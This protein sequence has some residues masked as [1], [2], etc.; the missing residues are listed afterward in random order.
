[1]ISSATKNA[2]SDNVPLIGTSPPEE[3]FSSAFLASPGKAVITTL[4]V[5]VSGMP[6]VSLSESESGIASD[7][8]TAPAGE[9]GGGGL[10]TAIDGE[11]GCM[12]PA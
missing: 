7:A 11:R 2:L 9:S 3:A 5:M 12:K 6:A 8:A 1:M 4:A 10:G